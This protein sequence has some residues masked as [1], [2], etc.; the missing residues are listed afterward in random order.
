[1]SEIQLRGTIL[2]FEEYDTYSLRNIFEEQSPF[3]ILACL[4]APIVFLVVNPFVVKEDYSLTVDDIVAARLSLGGEDMQNMAVLCIAR[5][6]NESCLVN[7]RSP[8]V[9]N[10]ARGEFQQV[11]LQDDIYGV[12]VPFPTVRSRQ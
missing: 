1:V 7:L 2:G 4:Q 3:R 9:I 12:S 8:L 11:I 5:K 10:T 6:E